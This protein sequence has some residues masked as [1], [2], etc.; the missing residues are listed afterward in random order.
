LVNEAERVRIVADRETVAFDA[1]EMEIDF[2]AVRQRLDSG[3]DKLTTEQLET[4]A[5]SFRGELLEG[6]DLPDCHD[7]QAW[8][9][10]E[11]EE[12]RLLQGRVLQ[13]L[14]ERL[15]P[16]PEAALPHARRLVE[17]EPVNQAA[18][19]HLLKLL[20][21]TGHLREA[22]QRYEVG[23]RLIAELGAAGAGALDEAW[24]ELHDRPRG[25]TRAEPQ[26]A[27]Q[28]VDGAS[29]KPAP[30]PAGQRNRLIGRRD[31]L[32]QLCGSIAQ[33]RD[34]GEEQVILVTGEP[35]LGKTRLLEEVK[36]LALEAAATV[37]GGCAYEAEN[38]RPYGPWI[39]ALRQLPAAEV[40]ATLG[41]DLSLLL[42]ELARGGETEHS[43]DRLFGAVVD[44]VAKR[45]DSAS[46]V[47]LAF[48]DVQWCDEASTALLHYTARMSRQ[49][50]LLILLAARDGEL[51][52]NPGMLRFLR[53][54]RREGLLAEISLPP[55]SDDETAELVATV[56]P[57]ADAK[58]IHA[59]STGNPLFALEVARS[60]PFRRDDLPQS[61]TELVADRIDRLPRTAGDL[62]RW[63]AV[64]G[65]TF[66]L[67][68]L[69]AIVSIEPDVLM[70]DL[71]L[72]ERHAL[73]RETGSESDTIGAYAFAHELVRNAVYSELS[74]PRRRLMHW[75][76]AQSLGEHSEADGSLAA[77]TAHHAMRAGEAGMAAR[78]CV[79]AGQRCLRVFA[80]DEAYAFAQKGSG[81]AKKLSDPER[82]RLLLELKEI[83][84]AAQRPPDLADEAEA[85]ERLA[86]QALDHGC[87][88]HARLGFHLISHLRWEGGDWSDAQRQMMRAELIS[89]SG[90]ERQRVVAIAEAARCLAMLERDLPQAEALLLEAQ[91][92]SERT[93]VEP[94]AI[95][96]ARGMLQFHRGELDSAGEM[97]RQAQTL[98][99]G[100]GDRVAEFH[101]LEHLIMLELQR[102]AHD[103]A[104]S[105]CR[106]LSALAEKLRE[107]S[108]GPFAKALAALV[109]YADGGGDDGLDQ[110]LDELRAADAK[111][112]LAYTLTRAA[113]CDI[114]QG[115][116]ARAQQRA[117]EALEIARLLERPSEIALAQVVLVQAAAASADGEETARHLA[118]LTQGANG[119]SA[120]VRR[121]I[122]HLLA[123]NRRTTG[124]Q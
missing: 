67:A 30:G 57:G 82:I 38:N 100:R 3:P 59:E 14:I 118:A 71:E 21:T 62:L 32:E 83:S 12:A 112:R 93:G 56:S 64:L 73:L 76:V 79:A 44:L 7:Y 5:R 25:T 60:L 28:P 104:K 18:R 17:I 54:L 63:G 84:F 107:G 45:A 70:S 42:P 37:L 120:D 2:A 33:V 19:A 10:A 49:R 39:D 119:V 97:F 15:A 47:I 74:E 94:D 40:D 24:Q 68:E 52:E 58:R 75:R 115:H 23:R 102:G 65:Q 85:L 105:L 87:I 48:D 31:E 51:P 113:A 6:L 4:M 78:A 91:A 34:R 81:Y 86:E 88:E 61:L 72:L 29:P 11:R 98:A 101:A 99:R 114:E 123:E 53:N 90:D 106:Q 80:N 95:P 69:R 96:D 27:P 13:H 92:L 108:E 1:A 20:A 22:E 41:P 110:A 122:E 66:G 43:R 109:S 55:L 116:E 35:G 26:P 50:P 124:S 121:A 111:Y 77:R 36:A 89:R 8:C 46:P 9:V 16:Q 117:E 103:Q